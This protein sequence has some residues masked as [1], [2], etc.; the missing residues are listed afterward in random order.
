MS[1]VGCMIV[2]RNVCGVSTSHGLPSPILLSVGSKIYYE[3]QAYH[4]EGVE[5]LLDLLGKH[6]G[7]PIASSNF[8]PTIIVRG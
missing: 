5:L 3:Q 4:L 7:Q 6:R 8:T 1:A 2:R